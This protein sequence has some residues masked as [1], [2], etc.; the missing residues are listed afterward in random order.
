LDDPPSLLLAERARLHDP[1]GVTH[2]GFVV[3]VVVVEDG[4]APHDLVVAGVLER[5]RPL[6]LDGLVASVRH[7]HAL[8]DFASTSF[9]NRLFSSACSRSR[10]TAQ[11][12]PMCFLTCLTRAMLSNWVLASW[13]LR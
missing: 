11:I 1:D 4:G 12:R 13:N 2:P 10:M 3:L 6:H 7:D 8:S 5:G 9:G